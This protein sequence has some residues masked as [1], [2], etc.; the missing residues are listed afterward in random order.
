[1]GSHLRKRIGYGPLALNFG[2]SGIGI[3]VGVQISD[4]V[5]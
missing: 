2:K 5:Y 3:S 1:M 4:Y